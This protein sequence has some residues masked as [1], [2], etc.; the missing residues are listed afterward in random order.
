MRVLVL[1]SAIAIWLAPRAPVFAQPPAPRMLAQTEP[2]TPP[3]AALAPTPAQPEHRSITQRWWFW[4]AV[5]AVVV[6]TVVVVLVAGQEP[7]PP[8]STLGNMNAF[9]GK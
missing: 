1:A 7:S 9:G 3:G 8:K 5:G 6:T 4:A 2:Y